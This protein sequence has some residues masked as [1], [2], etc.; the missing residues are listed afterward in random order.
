M[1]E[2]SVLSDTPILQCAITCQL[3]AV[4]GRITLDGG[5][6]WGFQHSLFGSLLSLQ[7]ETNTCRHLVQ[8]GPIFI[9]SQIYFKV[10][11]DS[12]PQKKQGRE[13]MLARSVI[14]QTIKVGVK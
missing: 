11:S 5:G 12:Q 9:G 3:T 10:L 4:F 6:L 7:T 14:E 2:G 1:N 8:R 13:L